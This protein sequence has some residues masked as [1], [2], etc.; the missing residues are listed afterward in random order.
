MRIQSIVDIWMQDLM[1][2]QGGPTRMCRN[3]IE[4]MGGIFDGR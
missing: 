2:L 1:N 4:T 3:R